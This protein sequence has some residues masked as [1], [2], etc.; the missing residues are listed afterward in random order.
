MKKSLTTLIAP[1]LLAT[2]VSAADAKTAVK[3]SFNRGVSLGV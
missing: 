1:A 2:L 3:T